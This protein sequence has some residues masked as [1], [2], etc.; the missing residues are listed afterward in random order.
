MEE[1]SKRADLKRE[2]KIIVQ[3]KHAKMYFPHQTALTSTMTPC[4]DVWIFCNQSV[5]LQEGFERNSVK[6]RND[7]F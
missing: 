5:T 1:E 6:K 4:L 3:V 7:S 2:K